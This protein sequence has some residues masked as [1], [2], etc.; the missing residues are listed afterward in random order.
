M[1]TDNIRK[2]LFGVLAVGLLAVLFK[3]VW[4]QEQILKNGKTE[5]TNL[6]RK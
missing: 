6:Q 2:I 4:V 1:I 3:F 5:R